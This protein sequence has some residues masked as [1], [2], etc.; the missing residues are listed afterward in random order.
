M[1][2]DQTFRLALLVIVLIEFPIAVF[3][4]LRSQ[5]PREPL[6]RRQ[7]GWFIL[8]TLRP[9]GLATW[10]GVIAFLINP[11]YMAWS[12]VPLPAWARWAGVAI[13]AMGGA[14]LTWTLV[15]L[16][17]NLT[18]TVVTRREHTLVTRGPYRFV[19]HP[20]YDAAAL[21]V[22]GIALLAANWFVFAAGAV[23]RAARA[24]HADGRSEPARAFRRALPG[25]PRSHRTLP[26]GKE[27]LTLTYRT[28]CAESA[29]PGIPVRSSATEDIHSP[30]SHRARLHV[31]HLRSSSDAR[32]LKQRGDISP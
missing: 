19:R 10:A 32:D 14:L 4:R 23:R 9:L 6:D 20:F 13:S 31:V 24:A 3:H 27:P 16:G 5:A 18:D 1:M 30:S 21:F 28:S 12:S 29:I 11:S 22:M 15:R 8:L 2:I 17:P 25:L 7:E 26:A